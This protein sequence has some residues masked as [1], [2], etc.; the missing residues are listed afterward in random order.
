MK[1]AFD[2]EETLIERRAGSEESERAQACGGA[3]NSG[4]ASIVDLVARLSS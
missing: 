4:F 3:E 2:A 1:R